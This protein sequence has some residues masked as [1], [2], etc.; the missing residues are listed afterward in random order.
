MASRRAHPAAIAA[1]SDGSVLINVV[2][3][4]PDGVQAQLAAALGAAPLFVGVPLNRRDAGHVVARL[5]GAAAEASAHLLGGRG[6]ER[7]NSKDRN[8]KPV[9]A[10]RKRRQ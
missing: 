5:D 7:G 4:L 6:A 3:L 2:A 8:A 10:R 1:A 9:R